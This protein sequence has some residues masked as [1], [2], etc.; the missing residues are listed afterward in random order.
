LTEKEVYQF[1]NDHVKI[2]YS[3][4]EAAGNHLPVELL[5]EIHSAFDHLKRIYVDG[6]SEDKCC[7]KAFSHL[8]R[9][10]LD[11]YKLKLKYFN[12]NYQALLGKSIKDLRLVDNGEFLPKTIRARNEIMTVAKNARLNEGNYDVEAAFEKWY[13]ASLLITEFESTYF[14]ESKLR[15]AKATSLRQGI[16]GVIIG[17][18]V[19]V[20]ASIVAGLILGYLG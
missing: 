11:A 7:E 19:G 12:V 10:A 3:E 14:D 16:I 2:I 17:L 18:V 6:L 13:E 1:Y 15:W 8:K 20:T 5:F 9:G 4:I